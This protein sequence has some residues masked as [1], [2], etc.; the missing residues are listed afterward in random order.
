MPS[1]RR[2][3]HRKVARFVRVMSLGHPLRVP[4]WSGPG[5]TYRGIRKGTDMKLK[6]TAVALVLALLSVFAITPK[7]AGAASAHPAKAKVTATTTITGIAGTVGNTSFTDG[8][9]HVTNF[10]LNSAGQLVAQGTFTSQTLSTAGLLSAAGT[11][12]TAP[13][14]SAAATASCTI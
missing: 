8:V 2:Q 14:T 12:F 6:V 9:L 3:L 5:S 1:L 13:V 4:A 7:V 10:A 11:S